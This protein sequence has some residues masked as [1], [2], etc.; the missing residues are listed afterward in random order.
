[1]TCRHHWLCALPTHP[2]PAVCKVCG[3][4]R[5]FHGADPDEN[6]GRA[7]SESP[8]HT[9]EPSVPTVYARGY[10]ERRREYA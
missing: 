2:T 5:T 4:E 6:P 9:Y 7:Y 1:M 8:I 10:M 3:A